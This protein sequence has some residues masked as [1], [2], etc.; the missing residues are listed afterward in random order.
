MYNN[1]TYSPPPH[2]FYFNVVAPSH[3]SAFYVVIL[4]TLVVVSILSPL[5]VV[6]N[7]LILAAI[8]RNPSLRTPSYVLLA[9]LALTDLGTGLI[10]QPMYVTHWLIYLLEP[11]MSD[12]KRPT[13]V[14]RAISYG[15][16]S[17]FSSITIFLMT[18]MSIERWLHMSRRS[19]ISV[20]RAYYILV[21]LFLFAIPLTVFRVS[22]GVKQV[23]S[24]SGDVAASLSMSLFLTATSI[25]YFKV[26]RIIRRHQQQIRA[27]QMTP[28][29]AQTSINLTKYKKSV[30][31]ILYIV[32][33]FYVGYIPIMISTRISIV[34]MNE[35]VVIVLN[36]SAMF[37]FLSASLNPILYMWRMSD[38]RTEVK[39]LV[40][41]V[42]RKRN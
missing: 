13:F 16:T 22:R 27:T 41:R 14:I 5:A 2:P 38:I 15:F 10:S 4:S 29:F 7:G 36:V 33:I 23:S 39:F 20:R 37:K 12:N 24:P 11:R 28:N 30:F 9:G 26:F 25:A 8:W 1:G 42:F 34:F 40:K 6:A 3:G 31:S 19:L 18:V 17:F 35:V 21:S 32:V